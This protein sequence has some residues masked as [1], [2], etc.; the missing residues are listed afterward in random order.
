[1]MLRKE[2]KREGEFCSLSGAQQMGVEVDG[3]ELKLPRTSGLRRK[4]VESSIAG[5]VIY[6]TSILKSVPVCDMSGAQL[7]SAQQ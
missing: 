3:R 4:F 6:L 2:D 7:K 1:M 5:A